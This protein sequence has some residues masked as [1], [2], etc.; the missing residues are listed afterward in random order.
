[1]SVVVES[2][3]D[4]VVLWRLANPPVNA[5]TMG[6]LQELGRLLAAAESDRTIRAVVITGDG[7]TFA[8]GADIQGSLSIGTSLHDFLMEGSAVYDRLE[9]SRLPIVAAINGP[10]LG[11]GN[12][13]ALAADIRIASSRARLGQPE[14]NL[15]IIPGWG[16]TYRLPSLVGS[17]NARRLLLSGEP[18]EADEAYRMG[19]VDEV[20][21]PPLLIEAAINLADRLASLPP[22]AVEEIKSL[23]Y[24]QTDRASQARETEAMGRLIATRDALEGMRAFISHRRP[25]FEGK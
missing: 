1:M 3:H 10:A 5:M 25:R 2:R 21:E 6:L 22:L 8:A 19:L 9:R 15:G 20:V 13:L 14:V 17:A 7:H 24:A 4:A 12:E 11:G 18:V 16:G 23:L